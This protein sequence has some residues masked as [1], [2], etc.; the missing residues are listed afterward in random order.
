MPEQQTQAQENTVDS[1]W[2]YPKEKLESLICEIMGV[3]EIPPIIRRQ[4][5]RFSL[6]QQM[7]YKEMARCIVWYSEVCKKE[8][9]PFYGINFVEN[10]R[11]QT[12]KYFKQLELDQ[13]IQKE[14]AKK[15]VEYQ[16]N[17]IIFKIKSL[18]NNKRK[19]KQLDINE[20]QVPP[21]S[22]GDD[23]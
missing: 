1:A 7:S 4:M 6:E 11:E 10:V 9:S 16:D 5:T 12:A 21:T 13:Q 23:R 20:I 22:K 14:S 8:I 19:P 2:Y 18:K 15:A 3:K 17:T